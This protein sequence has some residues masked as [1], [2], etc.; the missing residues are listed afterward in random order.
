MA[1]LL[2]LAYTNIE[3]FEYSN[4]VIIQNFANTKSDTLLNFVQS[5]QHLL[6]LLCDVQHAPISSD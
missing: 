3:I 6:S 1:G 4:I 2:V 5:V